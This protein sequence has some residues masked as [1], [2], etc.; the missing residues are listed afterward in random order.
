MSRIDDLIDQHCPNGVAY[1]AIGSVCEVMNGAA[2]KSEYFNS[3]GIGLPV[4]RIRDVN[5]EFSGTYYSASIHRP[6]DS[7]GH[8]VAKI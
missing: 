1:K 7:I 2:F 8:S 3:D 4:I 5:T 6:G